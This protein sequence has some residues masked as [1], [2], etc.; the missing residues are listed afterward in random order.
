[1]T[2]P[3]SWS[4]RSG[5]AAG[6]DA[7][8]MDPPFLWPGPFRGDLELEENLYPFVK[9]VAGVLSDRPLFFRINS[10]T[11][12]L[13]PSVLGP[14][15]W[16]PCSPIVTAATPSATNWVCRWR[17]AGSSSPVALLTDG[18]RLGN[19]EHPMST[20]IKAEH[21]TFSLSR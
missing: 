11:T 13:A 6:Y 14:I 1:M 7:V 19:K 4:E 9:L 17:R 8:I 15:F 12:G 18:R 21:L 10:Y 16:R 3:N 2:A 5:G 20:M